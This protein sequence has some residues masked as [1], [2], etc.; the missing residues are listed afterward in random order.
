MKQQKFRT[1]VTEDREG[2]KEHK[3]NGLTDKYWFNNQCRE[4]GN[5]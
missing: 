1:G 5:E 2:M 4:E 3:K